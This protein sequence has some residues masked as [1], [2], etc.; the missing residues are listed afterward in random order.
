MLCKAM[1]NR[2]KKMKIIGAIDYMRDEGK[3]END[4]IS[5]IMEKYNVTKEYVLVLLAP[6]T[7]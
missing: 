2:D 7:V 5:K 1:E 6:K 4:I 3:S